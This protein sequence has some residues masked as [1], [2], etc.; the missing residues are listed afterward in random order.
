MK[1]IVLDFQ[2]GTVDVFN[3]SPDFGDAEEYMYELE[4]EGS[5]SKVSDCQWMV[6]DDLKLQIH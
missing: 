6:V 1:I 5:I 4:K 2:T 3:Y